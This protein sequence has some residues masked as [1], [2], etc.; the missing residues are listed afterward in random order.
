MLVSICGYN[1]L[2]DTKNIPI[3][4]KIRINELKAI[5]IIFLW[6]YKYDFI[7]NSHITG[8]AL[9][10]YLL[11]LYQCINKFT[12]HHETSANHVI[13]KQDD[14]LRCKPPKLSISNTIS[15]GTSEGVSSVGHKSQSI[16]GEA[17]LQIEPGEP[18]SEI[19]LGD[20]GGDESGDESGDEPADGPADG[21]AD[22]PVDGPADGPADRPE[23]PLPPC[24]PL[25]SPCPPLLSSGLRM[26][27]FTESSR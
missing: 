1:E 23:S 14:T 26:T 5:I 6:S 17:I 16:V 24:P 12:L 9:I 3:L 13:N 15:Y 7:P 18:V 20:E 21:L 8:K 22:G 2:K 10:I 19:G 4:S 27:L 25:L 11:L